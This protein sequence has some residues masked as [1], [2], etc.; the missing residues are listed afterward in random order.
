MA[1]NIPAE[2]RR[3]ADAKFRRHL[4][5]GV[6][7]DDSPLTV[8]PLGESTAIPCQ[9]LASYTPGMSDAVLVYREGLTNIVLGEIV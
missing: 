2:T 7:A 3:I 4:W 8:T 1:V 5:R 9:R 6:V